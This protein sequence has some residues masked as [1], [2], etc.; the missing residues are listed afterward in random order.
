[1][2]NKVIFLS[3]FIIILGFLLTQRA[4]TEPNYSYKI[5]TPQNFSEISKNVEKN[6]DGGQI[7]F[8]VD[9]SNSMNDTIGGIPK[10]EMARNTL[11]EI[12]PKIPPNVKTGLRVYGHKTG[13]TYYQGCQASSLS[14]PIN[15]NN[16]QSILSSLYTTRAVGWTPITYSLKQ[17]INSDFIGTKGK[18]HIIL[19]T[20]GGENCDESPCTYVINL[21]KTRDDITIDVIAFDVH[22]IEANNQL[23]CTALMT[24]GKFLN[25]NS[26]EDLANS[27]F[28]TIG[29][30]KDVKGSIKIPS[31][32]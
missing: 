9:F 31:E 25:A 26:Q 15:Y 6:K 19:L 18:K 4:K 22:D 10:L 12:L 16:F 17:A 11:A 3:I 24:S 7:L 32:N 2:K 21:M 20:D 29:I 13:F 1:M 30:S 5:Y 8:I 27:L 28:E 23:R 14:V